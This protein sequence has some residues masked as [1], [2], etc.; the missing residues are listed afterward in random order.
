MKRNKLLKISGI[1]LL[2]ILV[3]LIA[4]PFFLESRIGGIL[5]SNVN[6]NINGT[7]DFEEANLSLIRNFPNA[8][9]GIK[10]MYILNEA[11][12]EG[13][14]LVK[15]ESVSLTMG[16]GELFK[17]AG[18]PIGIR[19]LK[20]DKAKLNILV[21]EQ[22]NAN[23]DIARE[24]EPVQ[25]TAS[26]EEGFTLDLQ[27]YEL[28]GSEVSYYDRSTGIKFMLEDIEHR[29]TGDLS[30]AQSELDTRTTALISLEM[31]STNYLNRNSIQLEALIGID[32]N[33]NKYSFL[34]NEALLNQLPLVF[35]GYVQLH[36]D[37]QDIDIQFRTPSSDFRNFLGVIPET[38][39]K[40]I[41]GV[42]TT[43]NFMVEGGFNGRVDDTHIPMFNIEIT[44]ENASFKYPDLPKSVR[45]IQI[46][47]LMKN[48]TGIA[49]DTFI[50][51]N[52]LT[53]MI[54]SDRFNLN[55]VIRE[56]MGNTR[57]EAHLD[58]N[59]NLA[60][61]S[62]AY[63][64]PSDLNLK[65]Q[66]QADINT[67]FDMASVEKKQYGNTRTDGY[68]ILSNFEYNS[69]ELANPVSIS[70][71]SMEFTPS[72]VTL[73]DLA[74]VTGNSDFQA[75]G[76]INNLLGYLFNKELVEGNFRLSSNKF[77]LN[78]FMVEEDSQ[79]ADE[80]AGDT[81]SGAETGSAE[82]LKIPSF[83]DCTIE[84]AA[85]TVQYDNLTLRNVSGT[86]RINNETAT[87][88]N[89]TSS[90]FDG[91][92][93][94]N[95]TVSTKE[96]RPTFSMQLGMDGFRIGET[97]EGLEL[98]QALAPVANA[99]EGRLNSQVDINGLLG[100][101]FTPDL[102]SISGNALASLIGTE[103]NPE[104]ASILNALGS[105]L[106]FLNARDF[107]LGN[108][109]TALSFENGVVKVQPFTVKYKDIAINVTGGHGFDRSLNYTATLDVPAAYLGNEV[110]DLLARIND[111]QLQNLTIPVTA[112][113]GGNYS[114]PVISTDLSS[115]VKN[116]TAQLVEIQKQK[117]IDQGTDKARD[118]IGGLLGG[119]NKEGDSLDTKDSTKTGVK[120]VLGGILNRREQPADTTATPTDSTPATKEPVKETARQILGGL[121][122][123][124]KKD[125]VN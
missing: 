14:T 28:T 111:Q 124:K 123:K 33:E 102:A 116:L 71:M 80:Q 66:L 125:S 50:E 13:D 97:F 30:L 78:D 6:D 105:K 117:L 7:F 95:G 68:F 37:Y 92:L 72:T 19:S 21:D 2:F 60:N 74:G 1:V 42:T 70:S 34:E 8:S 73:K 91:K 16:L 57:V 40:N 54:D 103:L 48:T 115:G 45:N 108:F 44:S 107:D 56:L 82:Q 119:N 23:Y 22:E 43:G 26:E 11:P 24:T 51:L 96:V 112:S 3:T 83:L 98:F 121:L 38:Y 89:L 12:F 65:G 101:D 93:A 5:K 79:Q 58:G 114:N 29:G 77:V 47:A 62:A 99:L 120:E 27:A 15:A 20:I 81:A 85:N 104:K 55:A 39:T 32:L 61:L 110:N 69:P 64:V 31:D 36:E 84:A 52:K 18:D 106:N 10:G 113:I 87:L 67:A 94:L 109:K 17:G 100:K 88:S 4:L 63:P 59:L 9:L 76:S 86:L 46:D 118:L 53:F 122:G 41:E 35:E 25:G 90:L 49:E 75:S